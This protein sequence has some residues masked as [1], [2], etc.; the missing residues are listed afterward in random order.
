MALPQAAVALVGDGEDVGGE[1]PEVALAVALH[2][3]AL[4]QAGDGLVGVHGGDDGANVGLQAQEPR[5]TH[6]GCGGRQGQGW[7]AEASHSPTPTPTAQLGQGQSPDEAQGRSRLSRGR[8]AT[9]RCSL[10][11]VHRVR[12]WGTGDFRSFPCLSG[13][14]PGPSEQMNEATSKTAHRQRE[15]R[16]RPWGSRLGP[17]AAPRDLLTVTLSGVRCEPP[18]L[19]DK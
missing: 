3:G 6:S 9:C 17:S 7:G 5:I 10:G 13:T 11:T 1:L 19:K 14:K 15:R 4:V 12:V 16:R 8:A 2:G 18:G